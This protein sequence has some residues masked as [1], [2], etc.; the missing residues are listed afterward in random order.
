[1][2][3]ADVLQMYLDGNYDI[4]ANYSDIH[5]YDSDIERIVLLLLE[6]K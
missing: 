5:S 6:A 2:D 1:M 4:S 3:G